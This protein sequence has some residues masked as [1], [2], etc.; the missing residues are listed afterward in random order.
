VAKVESITP[1]LLDAK[2]V[3]MFLDGMREMVEPP[4]SCIECRSFN[5]PGMTYDFSP[6]KFCLGKGVAA[7]P[8]CEVENEQS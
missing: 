5:R 6:C 8:W 2:Y 1:P 3:K 4:T 7:V